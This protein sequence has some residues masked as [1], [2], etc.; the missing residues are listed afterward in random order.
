VPEPEGNLDPR[1]L[2]VT[3]RQLLKAGVSAPLAAAFLAA[4]GTSSST[5]AATS[6]PS[7]AATAAPASAAPSAAPSAAASAAPSA[8][9]S[10]AAS[11]APSAA[12][13]AAPSAA[14]SAAPSAAASAPAENFSGI[15]IKVDTRSGSFDD[16]GTF[17][18]AKESWEART[19]GKVQFN[20]FSEFNDFDKKYTGYIATKD[21]TTDVLYTYDAFT[22][23]Y[24]P[25]L[26]DDITTSAGD[27]SDFVP[28]DLK[29]F[30]TPDGKLRA[31]PVQAEMVIYMFNKKRYA[32]AGIDPA[33]PPA[34]WQELYKFA[35]K[36]HVGNAYGHVAGWLAPGHAL[37]WFLTFY[38]ST[39]K[40]L[41]SDDRQQ[42]LFDNDE[43][44]LSLSVM[45]DALDTG[46]ADPEGLYLK[47]SYD[48][49]KVFYNDGAASTTAFGEEA[50][51]G[52]G[53]ASGAGA[54]ANKS[55]IAD[56]ITF[57][58]MPGVGVVPGGS[59]TFNG[60]EAFGVNSFGKNKAAAL[61]FAQEMAGFNSQKSIALGKDYTALPPSRLSVY[62]DPEVKASYPL[63]D[64]LSQQSKTNINRWGSPYFNDMS[65][66][67]DDILVKMFKKQVTVK[68]A[69]SQLVTATQKAIDKWKQS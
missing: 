40:P 2:S 28:D 6:Q 55:I 15:T 16:T 19:G 67:F 13:S 7:S 31:L 48:H 69:R 66:A 56:Q 4:C 27:T 59:G 35:D 65:A 57:A 43:F 54:A 53:R 60:F 24:G 47:T 14:A 51:N 23:I 46:F 52:L 1:E 44:E 38:N 11:A 3:R 12:A 49:S 41:L 18:T 68:D 30:V 39:G 61:S 58:L 33:N 26:F 62:E 50:M 45:L 9:A 42:L 63:A 37:I 29:T 17:K 64:M 20:V 25:R 32:D 21:G 10:A 22:Q 34:T 36:L 8:A 5:P